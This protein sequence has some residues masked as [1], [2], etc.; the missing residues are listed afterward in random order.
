VMVM[1]MTMVMVKVAAAVA[2]TMAGKLGAPESLGEHNRDEM[3]YYQTGTAR[4]GR[5]L[6][7]GLD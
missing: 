7:L 1:V 3:D 6:G 5:A 4:L 2:A